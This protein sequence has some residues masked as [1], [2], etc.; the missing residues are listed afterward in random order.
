MIARAFILVVTLI[1]SALPAHVATTTRCHARGPLPDPVCTPGVA[2]PAVT[3]AA[4]HVT[5]CAPGWTK[6]VRPPTS[7]T[8]RL[9]ATQIKAYGYADANP[10]HY[11]EDHL[12]SLE[13]GGDPSDARNLWPEPGPSPNPKDAVENLLHR[14]VCA[15]RITLKAA[16]REIANDWTAVHG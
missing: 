12:I 10:A 16:Q 11:E 7:Y 1:A 15:G 5:I 6:T 3:Q 8:N 2:D 9:K 13:L 14:E 4:V